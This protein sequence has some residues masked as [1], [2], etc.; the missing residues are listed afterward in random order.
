[1]LKPPSLPLI[2]MDTFQQILELDEDD[3][4]EFSQGMT[5]AYF[6]QADKAFKDM[7]TALYAPFPARLYISNPSFI[8][9]GNQESSR[10]VFPWPLSQ[11]LVSG[12]WCVKGPG[13][14]R[15]DTALWTSA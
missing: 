1:M 9:Q 6:T 8:L 2:D 11:R 10:V 14:M 4:V 3:N 7:D 13:C 12:A 5:W 15:K